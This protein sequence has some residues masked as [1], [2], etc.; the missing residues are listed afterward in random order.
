MAA[1]KDTAA[2][3]PPAPPAPPAHAAKPASSNDLMPASGIIEVKPRR[4]LPARP[5]HAP[6]EVT[7]EPP[8]EPPRPPTPVPV[9][10]RVA[11]A[12]PRRAAASARKRA[13]DHPVRFYV[14]LGVAIGVGIVVAYWLSQY[15]PY[16]PR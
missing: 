5:A 8:P 11:R 13:P 3:A 2:V 7:E 6:V 4:P 1:P 14:L 10:A 9:P 12:L 15:F 16:G